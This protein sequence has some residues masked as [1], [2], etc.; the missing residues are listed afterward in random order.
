MKKHFTGMVALLVLVMSTCM[1]MAQTFTY[2]VKGAQGFQ[3]TEKTR[4]GL[5]ISYNLG[6]FTM[7]QVEAKGEAMSEIS[8]KGIVLPNVAGSPNL[9]TESR[10]MAIPQGAHASLEVVHADRQ[11]LHNVEIAPALRIQ[12]ESETPET[13]YK[14]DPRVYSKN[15]F[16]PE[17][18]FVMDKAYIRGVDAVTVAITPFQYNPVTKELAVYTNIE[19][20]VRFEGGNG[21]FGEDRLR[22]PYWDPILAAEL[23]NYD[24]LPKIDYEARMQHW[25]RDEEEGAEYLIITPN[26]DA[27]AEYANQLKDYR[28]RQGII[29]K[30]YR[31]DEMPATNTAAMKTWFHNAYHN[32]EIPPVAV[33][34]LGDHNSNMAQ[35]IPAETTYHPYSDVCITDNFY[36]DAE[37]NDN[38]PDMVFSRLVAQN[39]NELPVFVGKQIEYEYTN[40]NMEESFYA[41]SVTALGWQTERWFQLCSEVFG[42]YMRNHG[43]NTNRINCIYNGSPGN[44]WSSAQ[45]TSLVASYFG[46]NGM[47]YIPAEPSE[48]GGWTGGSPDQV[49]QAVNNGTFWV[50]HRDHG[51]AEGWGEPAVR[52][53]HIDQMN[54]VG[55][56]PFVMSINCETGKFNYTGSNGNCFTEKWLRR[57]YNGQNAGA[58]GLLSPTEVSYSFVNDAY[59]WGVYDLF[60]GDFMPD[61]GPYAANTGNW[62]PAFGNVA[63]KYFL[64]QSSWPYNEESKDITYTMFTAHCDAFLRV[65]TQVPQVMDITHP[66]V[67]LVSMDEINV[68]A[69]EGCTISL[70]KE[71]DEGGW[72]IL[73]VATA[74]GETQTIQF[75]QQ[76]PPTIIHIVATGQNYLRYEGTMEVIPDAGPYIVY[77]DKTINDENG[78]GQLDFGETVN[79]D[80]TLKNVGADPMDAFEAVLESTS[81]YITILNGTA[82]YNALA[83]NGTQTLQNA[84]SFLVADNI[85]DRTVNAFTITVNNGDNAYVSKL[86]MKAF[87]PEFKLDNMTISEISGNNNGRLDPGET[88]MLNFSIENKGHSQAGLTT[89]EMQL[90][91]PYV[92]LAEN[93]F[94]FD[95]FEAGSVM[96]ATFEVTVSENTPLGY[97]FPIIVNVNSGHYYDTKDYTAKVGL[98]VEDFETGELSGGWTNNNSSP[99]TFDTSVYYEGGKSLKSGPIDNNGST[100]VSLQHEAGTADTVSFYFKVSSETSYDKLHF[101]IDNVE[102]ANWSGDLNWQRASYPVAAGVHT[103]KWTYTKDVSMASGQ[104]CAWIDYISLPS[105]RIMAGTAGNDITICEG[106][107]AQIVG[108]AIHHDNLLWTTSGDGTFDDATIATP[109]YTPGTQDLA[110][111]QVT[112][113]ITINGQD[114]VITDD[115]T[116]FIVDNIVI[117]NAHPDM[118]YCGVAEPQEIG[119]TVTGDYE[120]FYWTTSGD[121][122][123]ADM[124]AIETTYTPGEQDIL[125]GVAI[126][127][128]AVSAG[129]GPLH[130]S[131]PFDIEPLL[132]SISLPNCIIEQCQGQDYVIDYAGSGYVDGQMTI[133][134]NG[135][136][137]TL[138]EGQPLVLPTAALEPGQYAYAFNNLTNGFCSTDPQIG[139]EITIIERPVLTVANPIIRLCAGETAQF[140]LSVTGGEVDD[141]GFTIYGTEIDS[142]SFSGHEY[143]FE[144]TPEESMEFHLTQVS[145]WMSGCGTP[146]YEDLD[147]TLQ[148]VIDDHVVL[149]EMTGAAELDVYLTPST[150]YSITNGVPCLFSIE[151]QEAAELAVADDNLS[152]TVNWND[153]FKGNIVLTAEPVSGCNDGNTRLNIVVHNT[154]DV[155]EWRE[156]AKIYPNP[157]NGNV[158]IEAEGMAHVTVFNTMGQLVYDTDVDTDHLSINMQQFPAGSYIVRIV[159]ANGVCSKRVNVIR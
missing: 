112:L 115:M 24:Q 126:E 77:S 35:G 137:A 98:I 156:A 155:D 136:P 135:V 53:T 64:H 145:A 97:A 14:K 11:V 139:I 13:D 134:I 68:T 9:P 32:W 144:V 128:V 90:L 62:M 89:A 129:C 7:S 117:E 47:N 6:E 87:A 28:T 8:I 27:W 88:A 147:L 31:L 157:T 104:D 118:H 138:T 123:F 36:A 15:A 30:V 125:N 10:M 102:K 103:Y 106:N 71:G 101:Y 158:N 55:K 111:R 114:E 20:A 52:N 95:T 148:V 25:L 59:V 76:V 16:Y 43:Y 48:L 99:W 141:P 151:P 152:V 40:P 69:P 149:P 108:Y 124:N 44:I 63:G 38:L 58:V 122:T 116:L 80:I 131:Y 22:S 17:H 21:H 2:P 143:V 39:A 23:M 49:V 60:D 41:S 132:F 5:R 75:E 150:S 140:E 74:T 142:I 85:P 133:D 34:L 65:Y 4:D 94:Q 81:E 78:N 153:S 130:F 100:I 54:N 61:Y 50:Q 57:T 46:P 93:T 1:A 12:A 120:E 42:G 67:V 19:L 18:P 154:T 26:N 96:N 159:T 121:G 33:C 92:T 113:T 56:L 109:I 70:V 84:F 29:T 73:A 79:L 45:N 110:N 127:A 91:S 83:P 105:P 119:V 107:D 86:S 51:L 3:L 72:E 146:C 37:G 66:E 82:Q